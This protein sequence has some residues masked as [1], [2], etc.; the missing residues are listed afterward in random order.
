MQLHT[1]TPVKKKENLRPFESNGNPLF[2]FNSFL[3]ANI[4]CLCMQI[5]QMPEQTAIFSVCLSTAFKS[6]QFYSH[7]DSNNQSVFA[8]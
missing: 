2:V 1:G 3:K 6:L 5:K 8:S 7:I 4:A